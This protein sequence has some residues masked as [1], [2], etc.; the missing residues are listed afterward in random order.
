MLWQ[1]VLLADCLRYIYGNVL[2]ENTGTIIY[3]ML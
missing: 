3:T 1:L 2:H